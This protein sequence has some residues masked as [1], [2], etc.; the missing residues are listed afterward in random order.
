MANLFPLSSPRIA[1]ALAALCTLGLGANLLVHAADDAN[2]DLVIWDGDAKAT[3][4]SWVAPKND[5]VWLKPNDK[6]NHGGKKALEFHAEGA[7]WNGFGW[8]WFG[9]WPADAGTNISTADRLSLWVKVTGDTKPTDFTVSLVSSGGNAKKNTP[10]L[11]IS[12]YVK[13]GKPLTDGEWHQVVIPLKDIYA[14]K[15]DFDPKLAWELDMGEWTQ[16]AVKF[17]LF[18]DQIQF[19]T[20]DQK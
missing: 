12:K 17:S 6:E 14:D 4:Q 13:D 16:D 3:G 8:N 9:W 5:N 18:I 20:P 10:A 19:L 1:L 2:K 7:G 11:P 15:T